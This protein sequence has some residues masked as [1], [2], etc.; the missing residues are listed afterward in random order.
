M[1]LKCLFCFPGCVLLGALLSLIILAGCQ[2]LPP[3]KGP[4]APTPDHWKR[5]YDAPDAGIPTI[6]QTWKHD[7]SSHPSSLPHENDSTDHHETFLNSNLASPEPENS[8]STVCEGLC[9]EPEHLHCEDCGECLSTPQ[10]EPQEPRFEDVSRDLCN[11]WE[12][13]QDPVLNQL[14]EQALNSSYTLWAALERVIEAREIARINFAPLLPHINF[15]PSF[16]RTGSLYQNP[17]PGF[18]SGGMGNNRM[19]NSSSAIPPTSSSNLA[20]ASVLPEIPNSFRFV[21]TQYLVPLNL[22]YEVDLWGQLNNAYYSALIRA[23]A[24]SQAYLSVLLSLTADVATAYFELRGLDAQQEVIQGNIR[25]RHSAVEINRARFNAGLIV[26]LDVSRAEVELARARS[27][28][29]DVRRL[30]GLQ[31]NLLAT[32]VGIPAPIFSVAYHPIRIPPPVVPRGL[33]SELLCRRPDIAEAERNLAAAYRDIGVAYANFFPSLNLNTS[34]GF[35]SP[36]AHNLFS[37]KARYWQVGWNILQTVFDAGRNL[38]NYEYYKA[39]FREVLANYEGTV[40]RS[41]QDVEDA[42]VNLHQYVEQA[43][44]LR[45]AVNA[46]RITLELAQIRYN[47]GLINYL[48]VVD[49]ERQLLETEQSSVIVLSNRYVSTV[50]LIRALGGGWGPCET[51]Q[52]EEK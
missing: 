21:Q 41:F 32:L 8:Y 15:A 11:W 7:T 35:G 30:L 38:A 1:R 37:W 42:L 25:V 43:K 3:Y 5:S 19:L 24:A 6:P 46:A 23:Q 18:G 52:V 48:D 10:E 44:A 9:G 16:T 4:I 27:D 28:S 31:E 51:C 29:E 22:T 33:P 39:A 34:L 12:I 49:A 17:F 45:D 26:Y 20:N 36:F 2:L 47:R 14:E 40:L 50:M 13:F